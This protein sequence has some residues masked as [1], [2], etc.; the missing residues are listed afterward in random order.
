MLVAEGEQGRLDGLRGSGG[1]DD[2]GAGVEGE[3]VETLLMLGDRLAQ[4]GQA[5]YGRILIAATIRD[6]GARDLL[7]LVGSVGVGESLPEID[8]A[9]LGGEG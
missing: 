8:G 3:A 6:G 9:G 4:V 2:V 7:D 1:D 5:V